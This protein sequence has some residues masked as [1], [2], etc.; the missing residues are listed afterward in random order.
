M[1]AV[2]IGNA[3]I[4]EN[5][6]AYGGAAGDQTGKEVL[7]KN[8]YLHKKGWR[9]IRHKNIDIADRIATAMER[10]CANNNIGYDQY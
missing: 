8:W 4:D 7:T 10:A 1:S 6:N 2:K 3:S 5:G 9:I